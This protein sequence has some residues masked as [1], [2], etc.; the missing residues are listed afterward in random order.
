MSHT[1]FL[2]AAVA[3]L[4]A[5]PLSALAHGGHGSSVLLAF[6]VHP[7]S[8]LDHLAGIVAIGALTGL[9]L[10]S[11]ALFVVGRSVGH[12]AARLPLVRARSARLL[13]A[14]ALAAG[15]CWFMVFGAS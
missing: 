12:F 10:A 11:L 4:L 1:R 13:M 6:F 9:A 14:V 5:T 8:G 15:S 7:F 3:A 2:T